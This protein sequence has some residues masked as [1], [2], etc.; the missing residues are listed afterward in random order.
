MKTLEIYEYLL[1]YSYKKI[2]QIDIAK[3]L[4]CSKMLV[5]KVVRELE[6]KGIIARDTKNAVAV[7]NPLL[8]ASHLAFEDEIIKPLYFEAPDYKDTLT[9]LKKSLYLIT[10]KSAEQI[11]NNQEP[12]IITAH[13]LEQHLSTIKQYF[14]QVLTIKKANL[15][16]YPAKPIK[17]L[18]NDIINGINL[19]NKWQINM[20]LL[21]KNERH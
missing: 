3:F 18:T 14:N 17:F 12:K 10:S 1:H 20:D 13:V 21:R 8:L 7:I 6:V 5:S 2:Y 4:K 19:A 9:V 15:I 11:K 16:I